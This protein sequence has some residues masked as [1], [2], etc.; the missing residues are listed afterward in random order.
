V[1]Q[2]NTNFALVSN[3]NVAFGNPQ[4]D[5]KQLSIKKIRKQ[6]LNIV[7]ELGELFVALGGDKELMKH[8]VAHFKWIA[9]KTGNPVDTDKIRDSLTDIHVF[10]YG[11]H[12]LMGVDANED[13]RS[14]ING[15]MTRFIKNEQDKID[16]IAKHAALGV[17][18]VRFEGVFPFGIMKSNSDQPDAP[19]G[20]FLKSASYQEE[21]LYPVEFVFVD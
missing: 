16:T 5:P 6:C 21:R 11:A 3:M 9:N 8:A 17:T 13:M 7:D 2:S 4:G 12:H 10:A 15:V 19:E 14:V 1:S 18:D 20:K